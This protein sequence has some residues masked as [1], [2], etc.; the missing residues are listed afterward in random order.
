MEMGP[1]FGLVAVMLAASTV[2]AAEAFDTAASTAA[3]IEAEEGVFGYRASYES[4]VRE[5]LL[6]DQLYRYA[7]TVL[8]ST[9]SVYLLFDPYSDDKRCEVTTYRLR[10]GFWRRERP[11][12]AVALDGSYVLLADD[13][14]VPA[15]SLLDRAAAPLAKD[16]CDKLQTAWIGALDGV[17]SAITDYIIIGGETFHFATFVRGHGGALSGRSADIHD[18]IVQAMGGIAHELINLARGDP[19]DR[20]ELEAD[21]RDHARALLK[22]LHR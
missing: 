4:A 1:A 21:L 7:Q 19:Y 17:K 12:A 2:Q 14:K 18:P 13:S 5:L 10:P 15:T 8:G 20:P 9:E 16:V 11:V 6:P 3:P 22:L